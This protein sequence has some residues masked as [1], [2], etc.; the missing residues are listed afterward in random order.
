[1]DV[2]E[3]FQKFGREDLQKNGKFMTFI[4]RRGI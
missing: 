4:K 2:A 1:M 3:R